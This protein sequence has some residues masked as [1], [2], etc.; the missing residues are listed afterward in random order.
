MI[1]YIFIN[2]KVLEQDITSLK[3]IFSDIFFFKI[4]TMSNSDKLHQ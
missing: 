4:I 2:G 1:K 3:T